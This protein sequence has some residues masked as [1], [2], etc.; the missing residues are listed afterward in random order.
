MDFYIQTPTVA[1]YWDAAKDFT[2]NWETKEGR[3]SKT[4][5]TAELLARMLRDGLRAGKSER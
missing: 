1:L 3:S 5:K 2:T 4:Q